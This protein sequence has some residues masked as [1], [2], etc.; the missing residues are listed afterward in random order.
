[1]PFWSWERSIIPAA[2][3]TKRTHDILVN[4]PKPD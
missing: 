2:D 4:F 3:L 1:V